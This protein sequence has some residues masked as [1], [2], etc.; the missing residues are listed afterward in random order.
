M[1]QV[2]V[3]GGGVVGLACAIELLADGHVV[4]VL[5]PGVPGGEQA[6][7]YGNGTL[8]NPSSVIPMSAPGLW[9]KLPGYLTDPLGPLTIRWSYLPRMLPW[10]RR[11]LAAGST[12]AKVA[13]TARALRPLLADAPALHRRLAEQAGVGELI[14]RGGVLFVFPD[15]AAFEAEALAW[16]VRRDNGVKWLELDQDE[17][18]QREPS[19]DRHYRFGVL[20]EDNGQCR[21]PGA[22]VAALAEHVTALGGRIVPGGA[23]GLRI[24]AGRLR[25]VRTGEG[26]IGCDQAVIAAGAFSKPLA[27]AAGDRVVLETERGYHVVISDPGVE[28][29]YPVMP[30]DGKMACVM[31]PGGLRLAGQVELAGLRAAPDWRRAEVLLAFARKVY[32]ALP[33]DL[34]AER[35]K[36]WMGHRPSTPDG[37]P[38]LGRASGCKDVVHAFGHGHVGLTAAAMTGK[39]VADLVAGR[40]PPF[41]LAPYAA[42]RFR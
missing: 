2:V 11:F 42:A 14:G 19:L 12:A 25:A 24:E 8:L 23:S 35:V 10:L 37:L 3:I 31:T 26:E 30:S 32:P 16:S 7:S 27:L 29:R 13:A 6:A 41:D 5:E 22:Y 34:P 9:K 1:T 17:L 15:R 38:V 21:D 33:A 20:V 28:P 39:L 40:S 18:R 4:S 36:L